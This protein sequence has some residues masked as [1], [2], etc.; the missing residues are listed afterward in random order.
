MI[1]NDSSKNNI[2]WSY[3][4]NFFRSKWL[5]INFVLFSVENVGNDSVQK[6]VK[7]DFFIRYTDMEFFVSPGSMIP[8]TG[9]FFSTLNY[10]QL[11]Y[12]RREWKNLSEERCFECLRTRTVLMIVVS[13]RVICHDDYWSRG[14]DEHVKHPSIRNDYAYL[15]LS[16]KYWKKTHML[17]NHAVIGISLKIIL[18]FFFSNSTSYFPI[19]V[20]KAQIICNSTF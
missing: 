9:L 12:L 6:Y 11:N 1:I 17:Y 7:L 14:R 19:H 18:D 16:R 8:V 13:V 3:Q 5:V 10:Y 20:Y 4:P 15:T 2:K